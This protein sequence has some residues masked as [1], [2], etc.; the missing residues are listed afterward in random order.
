MERIREM[1][2]KAKAEADERQRIAESQRQVDL[3]YI[4]SQDINSIRDM[5]YTTWYWH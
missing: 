1:E 3:M 4:I 5:V 2:L